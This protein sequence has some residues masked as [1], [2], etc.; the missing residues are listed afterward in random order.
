M[1]YINHR[2]NTIEELMKVPEQN[3]IEL[4]V[5]YHENELI[6]HH[7]PFNHHKNKPE[8]FENLLKKWHHKGP[9]ILNI[10][11][12]GIEKA[13]IELM[14]NY[15]INNWFFLDLSM[16]YFVI[17]SNVAKK[18]EITG[19]SQENLAVRFSE[20]EP[21]EYAL[22][23]SGRAKWIWVDC[24]TKMP[25]NQSSYDKIKKAGFKICIVSPELQK[26]QLTKISEFKEQITNLT[27]DAVCT[28]R[29]DLWGQ[30]L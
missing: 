22:S 26:H 1:I 4:D 14:N 11:T 5:R 3:G 8:I 25:L 30:V 10:K 24:F 2:I 27:I 20:Y 29:P 12:E 6:L 17:Y 23:F 21:L 16:P 19:F 13:C 18:N 7:D 28:K 9:M 15:K